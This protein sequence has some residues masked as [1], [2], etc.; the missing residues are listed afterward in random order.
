MT[1]PPTASR[2]GR[3]AARPGVAWTLPAVVFFTLFALVPLLLVAVLAFTDWSGL[4]TPH[5]NGL[6]NWRKLFDDPVLLHSLWLSVLLTLLGVVVQTPLSIALGVWAAGKQRNRAVLSAIFFVPLLLSATAVSV[7]W[8]ALLD[9]NFGIPSELGWLFGDG[10]LFGKQ[11]T[12]IGVLVFVAAWQ[13]TPLHTLIY[14]GAARA[15]PEVLYQAAAIDGAGRWRQF[16]HVTLPQLRNSVITSVILMVV[17]G[18]TTF[19]T[20][21]ILTQGGPGTDTT[22]T[23]YYMYD[24]AF[25]SFDYG[26]GSAVAL[27]LVLVAT[28]ISLVVVRLSGYDRMTGTQEGI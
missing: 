22:I 5:F 25:K 13:F 24:K 2:A 15:I 6:S 17:G 23:A 10:N 14:Q 9:P 1:S 28:L 7:L 26:T 11:S 20:V 4:D 16:F 27:L 21:L 12:A 3:F 18:L 19:D 8:R